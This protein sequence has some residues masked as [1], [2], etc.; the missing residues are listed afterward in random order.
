MKAKLVILVLFA[1]SVAGVLWF[2]RRG[3]APGGVSAPEAASAETRVGSPSAPVPAPRVSISV[4]FGTEKKEWLE[5]AA[6]DFSAVH[7]EIQLQLVGKG[8]LDSAHAILDGSEKPTLWSPADSLALTLLES[9][10]ATKYKRPLLATGSDAPTA[11]LLSPLVFVVWEDRA[12]VLLEKGK[13]KLSWKLLHEA[14]AS[15]R[16][17]PAVGGKAEWGFVKLGHT[18]PT[19][20]N[21]G[22]Q[23]LLS[24][25][26]EYHG[27]TANLTV[28]DLLEPKY[29]AFVTEIERGVSKFE[30]STGTFMT[31]MIRF[32]PSKYDIAVVYESLAIAQLENAQGRW[33]NLRVGYPSTTLW[34]DHPIA[35]LT[36]DWVRP[37][38]AE[39]ARIFIAYL[40]SVPVQ[41]RAL[42]YGFRPA[43]LTVPLK[44]TDPTNPFVRLA[45]YGLQID[46]PTAAEPPDA[47]VIRN[48]LTLWSRV[49]PRH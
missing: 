30:A 19:R 17:W 26:F 20:S 29:Q 28:A 27:R 3:S 15:N 25:S 21:S 6:R 4:L 18:D 22:L 7:P 33:G 1:L 2:M 47:A 42:D 44:S 37:E 39:A 45:P 24:M 16:G 40:K 41:K 23:A 38:Q 36:G 12:K 35:L 46:L 13:G 10:W 43:D 8:S 49:V 14:L 9:D 5:G 48:L 34:S 11:L 31:D 32:G